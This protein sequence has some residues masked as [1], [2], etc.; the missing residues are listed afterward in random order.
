MTPSERR[1][2]LTFAHTLAEP[3]RS[4]LRDLVAK[5]SHDPRLTP[6]EREVVRLAVIEGLYLKEIA[7][8]LGISLCTVRTIVRQ[9]NAKFG[10]STLRELAFFVA[11]NKIEL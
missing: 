3:A 9:V 11:K 1:A 4:G 2:L 10:V 7:A 6:R 5:L 8:R